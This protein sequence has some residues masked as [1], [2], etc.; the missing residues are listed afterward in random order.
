MG[1]LFIGPLRHWLIFLCV[2]GA[3]WFMGQRQLHISNYKLFALTLLVLSAVAVL[4]VVLTHRTGE[5]A[6][7]EALGDREQS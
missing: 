7:R 6:T 5:R 3:V 4:L 2:L 1:K